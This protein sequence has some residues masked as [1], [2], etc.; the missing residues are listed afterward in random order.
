MSSVG[1]S[2]GSN[3]QDEVI[4]RNREEAQKAEA[5][6]AKKHRREVRRLNE[7]HYNEIEKIKS[8][9]EA[10]MK[11]MHGES[12]D[13]ISARD[14]R[15][16][17]EM[18][19]VRAA[20]RKQREQMAEENQRREETLRKAISSDSAQEKESSTQRFDKL[21]ADYRS[22]LQKREELYQEA[23]ATNREAQQRAIVDNR[24]R[25][26]QAH[27]KLVGTIKDER[28]QTVGNLQR[29]N[30]EQRQSLETR[31]KDQEQRHMRDQRRGSD[32]LLRTVAS[33]RVNRVDSEQMMREGFN[34]AIAD[35][36]ERFEKQASK[37][38]LANH[39][40][41]E[42][43]KSS[44]SDRIDN[45]I[46]RLEYEKEDL[47]QGNIRTEVKLK[48]QKEREIKNLR[49]SWGKN[50]ENLQEQRDELLNATN[51][52]NAED[53]HNVR[54][55]LG[56][57]LT[58]TNRFYRGRMEENNRINRQAQDNLVGDFEAR[59]A[60]TA[61][62]ADQ[63]IRS[64]HETSETEKARLIELQQTT[65]EASQ[66][67]QQTEMKNLR[68]AMDDD[69]QG[70]LRRMQDQMRKQELAHT[71]R[72]SSMVQKYE[73]QITA[74]KDQVLKERKSGE[75]NL[76]RTVDELQRAHKV[77]LDMVETKNRDRMRTISSQQ[78]DELRSL[79]KRHE[80]K[81]DQVLAEVKKT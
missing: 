32:Q 45:Q 24:T 36:R 26:E 69:K 49:D 44:A 54:K 73:K 21:S 33:E 10:Q 52:R 57:E 14:H 56:K 77:S 28:N 78:A 67:Q 80:E 74:L 42:F 79:N 48:Q 71:E 34:D 76:K 3:R 9:H 11:S 39:Q 41:R 61:V 4:R 62:T 37:E 46:R 30:S 40:A 12:K 22:G 7:S 15:Y 75:D 29:Q 70:A 1:S 51:D 18:E 19:E 43:S 81:L 38:R 5:E 50:I 6:A 2:D 13:A 65:R 66:R 53:I 27:E 20:H 64:I 31:L 55:Q 59:Q 58:E 8:S 60:H 63:R 72:M 68:E 16:N 25:L 23:L 17:Q 47:K 35:T